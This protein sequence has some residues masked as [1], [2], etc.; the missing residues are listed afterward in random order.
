[1]ITQAEVR[2]KGVARVFAALN[3]AHRFRWEIIDPYSDP[4]RLKGL[5]RRHARTMD[6]R[7]SGESNGVGGLSGI[8]EAIRRIELESRNRGLDDPDALAADFGPRVKDRVR[9]IFSVWNEKRRCLERAASDEDVET[10]AQM[11]SDLDPINVEFISL[12]SRRLDELVRADAGTAPFSNW[13]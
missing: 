5:L 4:D 8:W 2:H 3:L 10:F 7:G 9:E 11:L 12:S 6:R 13:A 1:M